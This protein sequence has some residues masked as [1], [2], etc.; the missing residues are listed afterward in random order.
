VRWSPSGRP[1]SSRSPTG[2]GLAAAATTRSRRSTKSSRAGARNDCGRSTRIW[3]R[4]STSSPTTT[5][6]T[7]LG[8]FPAR[9]MVAQ[10]LKAGVVEQGRLHRTEDGVPQGGVVSPLAAEHRPARDGKAAGIR[11]DANGW[12]RA[13]PPVL[14]RYA[15]DW[16][17]LCRTR[18][19]APEVKARL[20]LWLA[21]SGTGS[22]RGQDSRRLPRRAL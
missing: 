6:F 14:V 13:D 12:A 15:D 20:A 9:G 17:A 10:W 4:R 18:Q 7:L 22:Q 19:K 8:A 11:Y 21:P 5:S 16:V 1:G 3:R 2:F